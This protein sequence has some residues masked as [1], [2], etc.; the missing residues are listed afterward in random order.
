MN[1]TGVVMQIEKSYAFIMTNRG[2]FLKVKV[3][4]PI[5]N[6]GEVYTGEVAK[7]T[8]FY[9]YAAA[10]ASLL[11]VLFSGTASYAYYTPTASVVVNINPSIELKVNRWDRILKTT[12]L[13][14]DGEKVLSSLDIKNKSLNDGLDLIV[15]EAKRDDFINERYIESGKII[16]VSVQNIK[17]DKKPDISQFEEHAKQ[18]NLKVNV[19][20]DKEKN[21]PSTPSDN[22]NKKNNNKNKEQNNLEEKTNNGNKGANKPAVPNN[23]NNN[24][25]ENINENNSNNNSSQDDKAETNQDKDKDNNNNN[26]SNKK[27]NNQKH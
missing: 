14:S 5:P 12:P 22:S 19:V 24:N 2:E 17:S 15:E 11:F 4:K 9:K 10:A 20:K 1:N 6:I 21:I 13:N 8:P 18:G 25:N 27:K 7:E 23:N 3:A 26:N 16:T